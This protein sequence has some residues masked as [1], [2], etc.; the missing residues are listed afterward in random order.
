MGNYYSKLENIESIKYGWKRELPD[1]RDIK[2]KPS[3]KDEYDNIVD[4]R[5][6]CPGVY[7]QGKL[8]SCTANAIAGAYEFNE[9]KE[10]EDNLFIPSRLFIYYN[11]RDMEGHVDSDSGAEIRDGIKSITKLGVCNETDWPYVIDNFKLKPDEKCYEL[12][13]NHKCIKYEKLKQDLSHMKACL[14]SGYPFVFGF[15]VYDNFETEAV[16]RTGIMEM[17]TQDSKQLGGHA[18]MAV[19]Y[20]ETKK[21]FIIRN[22]WGIEWGDKGYFYMPYD[23]I[24]HSELASDFWVIQKIKDSD[25][26]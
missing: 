25:L 4:L 3:L 16:A 26:Q 19:G 15:A 6:N 20:N 11:E 12:A 14:S 22:S 1:F 24:L 17:P 21:V 13:K 10:K 8:G 18:V 5:K 7:N 23:Y 2:H 9:I